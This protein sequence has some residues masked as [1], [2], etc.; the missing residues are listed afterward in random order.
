MLPTNQATVQK[1]CNELHMYNHPD[2]DD[3]DDGD[4]PLQHDHSQL[5]AAT[6]EELE[7]NRIKTTN[8]L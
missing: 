6:L 5:L 7:M 4:H 1:K 8:L 3:D 2:D